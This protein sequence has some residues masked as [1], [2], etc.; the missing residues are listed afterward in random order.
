MT[1]NSRAKGA[2][3][4]RE[5][6]AILRERGHKDARRTSDG[7]AQAG[8]GDVAG[9]DGLHIEVKRAERV[10]LRAWIEQ[11]NSDAPDGRTPIVA[12]RSSGMPWR[13]DIALSDFLD[14]LEMQDHPTQ[15]E[16]ESQ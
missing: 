7:R 13:V 9:I 10:T 3:G 5:L 1:L 8:R 2:R 15:T 11:A 4:E 12:W 14:L 6:I 16:G